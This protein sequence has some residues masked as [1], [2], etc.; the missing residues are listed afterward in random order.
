MKASEKAGPLPGQWKPAV[1]N[2]R[3]TPT[4]SAGG[5][6]ETGL[7]RVMALVWGE[8]RRECLP[9]TLRFS[10]C[11]ETVGFRGGRQLRVGDER[12]VVTFVTPAYLVHRS[13]FIKSDHESKIIFLG[14]TFGASF[15]ICRAP[16]LKLRI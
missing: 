12:P 15:P 9:L 16:I 3:I 14:L 10:G 2:P 7:K 6:L 13:S 5:S 8:H 1:A 11:R 4:V